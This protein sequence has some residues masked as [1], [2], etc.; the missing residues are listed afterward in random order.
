MGSSGRSKEHCRRR[1][2]SQT[3]QIAVHVLTA[4][5]LRAIVADRPRGFGDEPEKYHSDAI[6]L[7]GISATK[8]MAAFDPRDGVD[9]VWPGKGVI[10]SQRLSAQ[11]TKS[12][13]GKIAA[14]PMYA[15]MTIR[16]WTT[17]T[18]LVS[19]IED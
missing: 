3:E 9:T 1:S 2:S 4:A 7:M 13:L 18:K 6:F 16:S 19:L 15:S 12:R 8:A 14:S 17:T 5:K 10:Y 11:R